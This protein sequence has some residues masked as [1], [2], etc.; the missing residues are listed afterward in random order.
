MANNII[1]NSNLEYP[2]SS[3]FDVSK[4]ALYIPYQQLINSGLKGFQS[5]AGKII[6]GIMT[7]ISST[8]ATA[9]LN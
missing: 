6:D 7:R 3:W 4:N 9:S 2:G 1:I 5:A 8:L